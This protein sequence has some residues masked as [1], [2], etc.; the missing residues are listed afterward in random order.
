MKQLRHAPFPF[1]QLT[2]APDLA[3]QAGSRL[4]KALI[5]LAVP[6]RPI[7]SL[8]AEDRSAGGGRDQT[9]PEA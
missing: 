7:R 4:V 3:L 1:S 5:G 8:V 9:E 2:A 6:G